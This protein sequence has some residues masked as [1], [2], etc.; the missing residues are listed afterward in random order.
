MFISY[1]VR[2]DDFFA[3]PLSNT[4]GSY[5]YL[6]PSSCRPNGRGNKLSPTYMSDVHKFQN[7]ERTIHSLVSNKTKQKNAV[8][9]TTH[10]LLF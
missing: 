6:V 1:R 10:S 7:K 8:T 4:G 2:I 9:N 3:I 5:E